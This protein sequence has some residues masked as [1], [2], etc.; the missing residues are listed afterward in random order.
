MIL[1]VSSTKLWLSVFCICNIIICCCKILQIIS[2]FHKI[3]Q[4]FARFCKVMQ[5]CTDYLRS[6]NVW[7][8]LFCVCNSMAD[9]QHHN[10]ICY[11]DRCISKFA[12]VHP[13]YLEQNWN[14]WLYVLWV[15]LLRDWLS[16]IIRTFIW[17]IFGNNFS[18]K[19]CLLARFVHSVIL[20]FWDFL[21]KGCLGEV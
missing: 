16:E 8:S 9:L 18:W 11:H 5:D 2:R 20:T 10:L 4:N 21:L 1:S 17:F 13:P 14:R 19:A 6:T 12:F 15:T 3:R 7:L